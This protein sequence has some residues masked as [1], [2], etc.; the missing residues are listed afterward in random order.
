MKKALLNTNHLVHFDPDK[1]IKLAVDA[2]NFAVEGILMQNNEPEPSID[3]SETKNTE[4]WYPISYFS[5][6]LKKYQ[7]NYTITE[8]ETLEVIV[9]IRK[10]KHYLEGKSFIIETD[11]HALCQLHRINFKLGRLHRWAIELSEFDYEIKYLSGK[12]HPADCF[13]R[14][15]NE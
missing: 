4:K 15:Q 5:Q 2:S 1:E 14:Y 9:G 8:K 10:F 11:H 13:S 12:K 6:V 3:N 7:I